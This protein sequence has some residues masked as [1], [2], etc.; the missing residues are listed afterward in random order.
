[1]HTR[2]T[3]ID[4]RNATAVELWYQCK[5]HSAR[6]LVLLLNHAF[7]TTFTNRNKPASSLLNEQTCAYAVYGIQIKY[8]MRMNAV[9]CPHKLLP[10]Y[11]TA[12]SASLVSVCTM[13]PPVVLSRIEQT[14]PNAPLE[15]KLRTSAN[16]HFT[17]EC[18]KRC[19]VCLHALSTAA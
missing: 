19:S 3:S 13:L 18:D 6:S 5:Q 9:A 11:Y 10:C 1:V 2:A 4:Q 12:L 7:V 14:N 17:V 16:M 8:S 15:A